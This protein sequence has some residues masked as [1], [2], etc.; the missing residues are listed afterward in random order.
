MRSCKSR[1]LVSRAVYMTSMV[2]T[3]SFTFM[4]A[5]ASLVAQLAGLPV[6][7]GTWRRGVRAVRVRRV[8]AGPEAVAPGASGRLVVVAGG[9][10]SGGKSGAEAAKGPRA[11]V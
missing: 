2:P 11:P 7:A 3:L 4:L 5:G 6:R 8:R 9:A 10:V 1:S